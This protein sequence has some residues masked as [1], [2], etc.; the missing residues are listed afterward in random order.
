MKY[1]ISADDLIRYIYKEVSFME[2]L[3]IEK[4]IRRDAHLREQYQEMS[5]AFHQLDE[6]SHLESPTTGVLDNILTYSKLSN[7][8]TEFSA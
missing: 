2:K 5:R 4:A 8:Q 7:L 3:A 6:L 1:H